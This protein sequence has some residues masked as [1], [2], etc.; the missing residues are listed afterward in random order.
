VDE[1]S[2]NPAAESVGPGATPGDPSGVVIEGADNPGW[3]PPAIVPS[4]WDGWPAEWATPSW[5]GYVQTLTDTAWMCLDLNASLLS[6]MPPYLVGAAPT[7]DTSWMRNP[8][9]DVYTSWEEFAKQLFWDYQLGEAFVVATARYATGWPA[10]FHVVPPYLVEVELGANGTRVYTIGRVDVSSDM[11]HIRYQ[12]SVD[13]ARGHGPL[14]AGRAR[15][16]AD[17]VLTRY[18][19]GLVTAGGVPTS[20]L[21]S[22]ARLDAEQA[23]MLKNQ[24]LTARLSGIG[25]PAVLSGGVT[26]QATQMSPRDMA[27][28][29]VTGF[30]EARI[31]NLLGVPGPLVGLPSGGDPLTYSTAVMY[32]TQHWRIGLRPKAQ[33][34]MG[35]LS[36]WAL[37]LGTRVEVNRDAYIEAEPLQRA[38]AAQILNSI[39]DAQ[40]NPALTVEEIRE[41]ERLDQSTAP[42]ATTGVLR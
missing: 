15:V 34:V 31:A 20:I 24:W 26:W 12:S 38:Q 3:W 9:P 18:S 21:T 19:T 7:L 14:E 40:G 25:E 27:L 17:Q 13:D 16:I 30:T 5:G 10:R 28:L 4:P 2:L 35:A 42:D 6:T 22:P 32:F 33:A 8:D 1:R 29:D 39:K 23:Q 41:A 36:E 37:P 11:L